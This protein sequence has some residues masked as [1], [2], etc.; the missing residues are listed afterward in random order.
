MLISAQSRA[1]EARFF[2]R[3]VGPT[4]SLGASDLARENHAK[5]SGARLAAGVSPGGRTVQNSLFFKRR[6]VCSGASALLWRS[7]RG[8]QPRAKAELEEASSVFLQR[9]QS[10]ASLTFSAGSS[11][12]GPDMLIFLSGVWIL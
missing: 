6:D 10:T 8:G 1:C 5:A 11:T 2:T 4:T 9:E 12:D 7:G 3:E